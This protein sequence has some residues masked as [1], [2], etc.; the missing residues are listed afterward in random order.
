MGTTCPRAPDKT[1][2]F[3][4]AFFVCR[5]HRL[6][7]VFDGKIGRKAALYLVVQGVYTYIP[8]MPQCRMAS[9]FL[10]IKVVKV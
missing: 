1:H 7:V 10:E 6:D 3:V 2:L 5:G 4:G 9:W 8:A